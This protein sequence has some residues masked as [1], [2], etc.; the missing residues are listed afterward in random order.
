MKDSKIGD[1]K[2]T[3]WGAEGKTD[4]GGRISQSPEN[5]AVKYYKHNHASLNSFSGQK[6]RLWNYSRQSNPC[7]I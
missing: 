7:L 5:E 2:S 3:D 4:G 1:T 6:S